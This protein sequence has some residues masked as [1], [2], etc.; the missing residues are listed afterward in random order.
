MAVSRERTSN[1]KT[2]DH[3][4]LDELSS[5]AQTSPRLRAHHNF[6]ETLSDPC[7]RLVVAMEPGSYLQPHRHLF[8]AKPELFVILRGLVAVVL[9]SDAGDVVSSYVLSP[10]SVTLG[11]EV[12]AE[13]WHTAVSFKKGSAFMEIKPG[14]F[15]PIAPEDKAPWAPAEGDSNAETFL[16]KISAEVGR[17][18]GI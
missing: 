10:D 5:I 1:V 7:Q 3:R 2:I 15:R 6:H 12:P 11:F 17:T 8:H 16:E 4:L 9:F 14:P 18:C 13:T